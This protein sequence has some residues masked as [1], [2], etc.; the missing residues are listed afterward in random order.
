MQSHPQ[1]RPDL[2]RP[3]GAELLLLVAAPIGQEAT[4]GYHASLP[5]RQGLMG[6]SWTQLGGGAATKQICCNE[7]R[8][9]QGLPAGPT[10]T[11]AAGEPVESTDKLRQAG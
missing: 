6:Q 5:W 4:L 2:R 7:V 10:V 9:A 3:V 11:G 1:Y 8:P